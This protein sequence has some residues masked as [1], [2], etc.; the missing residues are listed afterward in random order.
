MRLYNVKT[1]YI[2]FLKEL[3]YRVPDNKGARR[4]FVGIIFSIHGHNYFAPLSSPKPKHRQLKNNKDLHKLA[5]G[6]YGVINFNNMI[7]IPDSE[8]LA[9]DIETI[10]DEH[11]RNLLNAQ[12]SF[13]KSIQE[14]LKR[15]AENLYNLVSKD[16][17]ILGDFDKRVKQRCVDFVKLQNVYRDYR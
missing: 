15:K 9:I 14:T 3:D 2:N 13:M 8:L 1:D 5:G 17:A 6:N 10:E 16:E 12:L 7:P 11:Y 4:P